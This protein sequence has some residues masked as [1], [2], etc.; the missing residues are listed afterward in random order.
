MWIID[1]SKCLK[2]GMC[3]S[4]CPVQALIMK[5]FPEN[6]RD[7]CVKCRA[8]QYNCPAGAITIM[9]DDDV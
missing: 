5:D 6:D 1:K 2:C 8:C 4:A 3:V 7:R 9:S